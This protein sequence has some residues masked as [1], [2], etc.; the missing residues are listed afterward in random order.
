M[1]IV[2]GVLVAFVAF[3]ILDKIAYYYLTKGYVDQI[4]E[5]FD[6][7]KNLVN[8]LVL[9][10]LLAVIFFGRMVW[11][12]TRQKRLIGIA[13]I[14]VLLIGHSLLLWLATRN[15]FFDRGGIATK[16]YVVTRDGSVSYG[17]RAGVDPNTGRQCR[18]VTAETL[19]RLREYEKGRRPQQITSNEPVFFEPRTGEPIVW[20]YSSKN[21]G[22]EIFD[23]M[24]FHPETGEELL[25]ITKET[26][27]DWKQQTTR[28]LARVPQQ[29][30]PRRYAFFDARSG[31]PRVWYSRDKSGQYEFYDSPGFHPRSGQV[32]SVVTPEI[33]EDAQSK[34]EKRPPQSVELSKYSPF[35]PKTGEARVWYSR[36]NRGGYEFFDAPGFHPRTGEKLALFTKEVMQ[37]WERALKEEKEKI[38]R[39]RKTKAE[40]EERE[41]QELA[42]RQSIEAQRRE[43][44]RLRL[45]QAANFCDSLAANPNDPKRV[46]DGVSF[47]ALKVNAQEAVSNCELAVA[48]N[49]AEPRFKYQLAR[50]LHW[51]NRTRA[52]GLFQ[53][54]VRIR[55]PAAFDNLGWL[56]LTERKNPSQ[57]IQYFKDGMALGDTDAMV[58]L[59]EMIDRGHL[60]VSNP[61]L[62]K[63]NLLCRAG[64]MGNQSAAT[65]CQVVAAAAREEEQSRVQQ[66]QQ[67]Q[68]M[69]QIMGGFLGNLP[70]RP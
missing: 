61:T 57:A 11:S 40:N 54:L 18:P 47:D 29:V 36:N 21:N 25:P 4:G 34:E 10:T 13:G 39:E 38:E 51:T 30:D 17:E 15:Q 32:L 46:G 62:E 24:G 33:A 3:W 2:G 56:Y 26:V 6:L 43:Q 58:S 42:A 64:Q 27:A 7:N 67:Q 45:T 52:F 49:P 23:L 9:A 14:A 16:C 1:A 66:L 48:Q 12:L 44:E 35:D 37:E 70:R 50:A 55:Y 65:A 60:N 31:A 59:A 69:L 53:E 19:E 20:Y 8:A 28:R 22:I 63:G 68:M 41:R 5:A